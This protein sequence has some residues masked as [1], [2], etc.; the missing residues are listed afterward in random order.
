MGVSLAHRQT[1][2]I[3]V[4][5][6]V[7][8]VRHSAAIELSA[9]LLT[10]QG[11]VLDSSGLVFRGRPV[12]P[13]VRLAP[14]L[15]GRADS[16]VVAL[17]SVPAGIAHIRIV[18]TLAD[19]SAHLEDYAPGEVSVD[20]ANG[21]PLY[22]YV[23]DRAGPESTAIA[24]DLDLVERG[25]QV[26]AVGAGYRGGFDALVAAHGGTV[27]SPAPA[28]AA[29]PRA[30]PIPLPDKPVRPK[31]SR[32]NSATPKISLR[33]GDDPLAFVKMGLGWDPVRVQGQY[34]LR[35]VDIDLDASALLFAGETLVDAAFFG[36]LASKDGSVR[37]L[38]DNLTGDG[39]GDDE[40]ITV[41]LTRLPA[42][43]TT[44]VF[45][46]TSYAGHTFELVRN[47]FWRLVNGANNTELVRSNLQVGGP[48][49][50]MVVAKLY[51]D[52]AEWKVE[53]I[54]AP[55]QAGHPVE[56]AEQVRR[57]LDLTE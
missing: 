26:R 6:I 29:A 53:S 19:R 1:G 32:P 33:N 16:L 23:I 22:D 37:H 4:E 45:V 46:V 30:V 5:E 15:G 48:N 14:G 44:V 24:V 17:R 49:T 27:E 41:D 50:G 55:I 11:S 12:G 52:G 2:V 56:A 35:E 21:N 40:V 34:G 8:S 25:W 18:V 13:G 20:D 7:V 51:R 3:A 9:L 36:G 38:G 43:I 39:E 10:A 42:Q 54:G 28:P 47:A 57:F 31:E